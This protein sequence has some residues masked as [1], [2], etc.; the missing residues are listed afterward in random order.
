MPW[1]VCFRKKCGFFPFAFSSRLTPPSSSRPQEPVAADVD[2]FD[3]LPWHLCTSRK[4]EKMSWNANGIIRTKK[5]CR[6]TYGSQEDEKNAL[7]VV[8]I[9]SSSSTNKTNAEK[10]REKGWANSRKMAR[11]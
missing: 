11:T 3:Q 9:S 4:G 2:A 1:Y 10:S 5:M 6:G 7:G 8:I